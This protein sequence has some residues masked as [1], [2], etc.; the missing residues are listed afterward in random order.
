MRPPCRCWLCKFGITVK[1]WLVN[2]SADAALMIIDSEVN[3]YINCYIRLNA[4]HTFLLKNKPEDFS[5]L[6]AVFFFTISHMINNFLLYDYF[7]L[8]PKLRKVILPQFIS[9][10]NKLH[11]AI[12]Y[13]Q[14]CYS[15]LFWPQV[16]HLEGRKLYY[17]ITKFVS[18]IKW[19]K[20]TKY[21]FP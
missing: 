10:P 13:K 17:K 11:F 7:T 2:K 6:V 3:F 15:T 19:H 20:T 8:L 16:V 21:F 14:T 4:F 1:F 9:I 12:Q 5:C 18:K